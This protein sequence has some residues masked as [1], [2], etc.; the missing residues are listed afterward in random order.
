MKVFTVENLSK[1]ECPS[2]HM[3]YL[4]PAWAK[5]YKD[6]GASGY[7]R[8]IKQSKKAL[9]DVAKKV[10]HKP[11]TKTSRSLEAIELSY[12]KKLKELS[13]SITDEKSRKKFDRIDTDILDSDLNVKEM[14]L[15]LDKLHK[16]F[17][18]FRQKS[19]PKK[20]SKKRSSKSSP[21][22]RQSVKK[23]QASTKETASKKKSEKSSAKTVPK[24]AAQEEPTGTAKNFSSET[25]PLDAGN[26]AGENFF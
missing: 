2:C 4:L 8:T 18:D 14:E 12:R 22:S 11:L 9:S 19:A 25:V 7:H 3:S 26:E 17:S 16:L 24:D 21:K 23:K 1:G 20:T 10:D 5:R 15:E 13:K 6:S